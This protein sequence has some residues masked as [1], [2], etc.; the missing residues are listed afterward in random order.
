V[1]FVESFFEKNYPD[2]MLETFRN[3]SSTG[4]KTG[5]SKL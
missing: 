3:M 4:K 1:H 2:M 5:R